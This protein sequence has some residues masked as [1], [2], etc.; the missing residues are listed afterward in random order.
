[1]KIRDAERTREKLLEATLQIMAQKGLRGVSAS[2]VVKRSKVS[3][4]TLFHHFGTIDGLLLE[5]LRFFVAKYMVELEQKP[6]PPTFEEFLKEMGDQLFCASGAEKEIIR[7]FFLFG[8]EASRKKDYAKIIR[9]TLV[10]ST[11][12]LKKALKHYFPEGSDRDLSQAA[13]LI[14]ILGDGFCFHQ[15]LF[16]KKEMIDVWQRYVNLVS[17]RGLLPLSFGQTRIVKQER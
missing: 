3:K 11:E 16:S 14:S 6:L 12:G 5:T 8:L 10:S 9:E 2:E 4:G 7:A 13:L 15:N 17:G 1:M